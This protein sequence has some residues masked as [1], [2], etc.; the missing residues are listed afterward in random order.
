[1]NIKEML[2]KVFADGKFDVDALIDLI[3][4]VVGKIL[5]FV[6]KEEGYEFVA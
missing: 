1:M 4:A 3:E 6:A 2:G 5:G